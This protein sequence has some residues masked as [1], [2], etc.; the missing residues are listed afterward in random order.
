MG[1]GQ[2]KI[3]SHLKSVFQHCYILLLVTFWSGERKKKPSLKTFLP[4]AKSLTIFFQ[5]LAEK[6]PSLPHDFF[7]CCEIRKKDIFKAGLIWG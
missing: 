5:G 1:T 6:K 3:L 2:T 4:T 7:S